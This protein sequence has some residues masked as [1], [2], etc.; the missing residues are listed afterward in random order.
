MNS[1]SN[2]TA[3]PKFRVGQRVL[4]TFGHG[5]VERLTECSAMVH[6]DKSICSVIYHGLTWLA[7]NDAYSQDRERLR[8]EAAKPK[9]K[10]GDRV[11]HIGM[12]RPGEV[13]ATGKQ[14][15]GKPVTTIQFSGIPAPTTYIGETGLHKFVRPIDEATKPKP[16][17]GGA[18]FAVGERV[19]HIG[20]G[21]FGEVI[22]TAGGPH[23]STWT[24]IKFDRNEEPVLYTSEAE[25]HRFVR[26]P[27]ET[28]KPE[29]KVGERVHALTGEGTVTS[30]RRDPGTGAQHVDVC[31]V[32]GGVEHFKTYPAMDLWREIDEAKGR[33]VAAEAPKEE[34]LVDAARRLGVDNC[35]H[36]DAARR[37]GVD[38][39]DLAGILGRLDN[40]S[41][42]LQDANERVDRL[43]ATLNH[44]AEERGKAVL[45]LQRA[46]FVRDGL[47]GEWKPPVNQAA[48]DVRMLRDT[49]EAQREEIEGLKIR[50]DRNTA[51]IRERTSAMK[52]YRKRAQSLRDTVEAQREYIYSLKAVLE[53]R[54]SEQGEGADNG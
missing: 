2:Q 4:T 5:T 41:A 27:N 43:K 26:H 16:I 13:L 40:L 10:V 17:V 42:K 35:D 6:Y 24:A 49:V 48:A 1:T 33:P 45:A 19:Y 36:V 9:F 8:A 32:K 38:N 25:L 51:I 11:Y 44:T 37:L 46:G 54:A 3:E 18:G 20:T 28:P 14:A 30:T 53:L 15:T 47:S 31:Y 22:S 21:C 52:A 34:E 12:G 50:Y 39:C 29:F 7:K 23:G